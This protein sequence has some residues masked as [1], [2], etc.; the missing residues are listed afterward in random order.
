M[1]PPHHHGPAYDSPGTDA[2]SPSTT[3]TISPLVLFRRA[4]RRFI[5]LGYMLPR[6]QIV[7]VILDQQDSQTKKANQRKPKERSKALTE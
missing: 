6:S 5:A 4:S 3:E 1:Q 2:D 7:A